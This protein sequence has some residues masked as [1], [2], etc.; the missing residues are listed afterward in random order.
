VDEADQAKRNP[1]TSVDKSWIYSGLSRGRHAGGYEVPPASTEPPFCHEVQTEE[2]ILNS[3]IANAEVE[4]ELPMTKINEQ[5]PAV[6]LIA[7][8]KAIAARLYPDIDWSGFEEGEQAQWIAAAEAAVLAGAEQGRREVPVIA[9]AVPG[10]VVEQ[11]AVWATVATVVGTLIAALL[12]QALA[13]VPGMPDVPGWLVTVLVVL[14]P[15]VL[16]WLGAW[17]APHTERPDLPSTAA[18]RE[19]VAPA[20]YLAARKLSDAEVAEIEARWV[21]LHGKGDH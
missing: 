12:T 10:P 11:R 15:A 1:W 18:Y 2:V 16:T 13:V 19:A 4:T 21:E 17:L 6:D 8:A 7:V 5:E 3:K 9:G 20:A 14:G